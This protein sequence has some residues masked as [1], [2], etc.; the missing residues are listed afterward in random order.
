MLF[1]TSYCN[2]ERMPKFMG[3]RFNKRVGQFDNLSKKISLLSDFLETK[4]Q[5]VK[6]KYTLG[7]L[8]IV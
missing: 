6:K 4:N 7:E 3:S 1:I 2:L 8:W 5:R